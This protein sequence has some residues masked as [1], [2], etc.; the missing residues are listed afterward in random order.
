MQHRFGRTCV[1]IGETNFNIYTRRTQG[2]A[3]VGHRSVR[4]VNGLRGRNM[5]RNIRYIW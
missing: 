1:Y 3:L 2:H 5:G 4:Q